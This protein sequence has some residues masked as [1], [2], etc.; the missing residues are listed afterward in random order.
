MEITFLFIVVVLVWIYYDIKRRNLFAIHSVFIAK[1]NIL[2]LEEWID[3]HIQ[4]GF[5]K[6]YLYDN[7]KVKKSSTNFEK[8][9]TFKAGKV[10]KYGRD[11]DKLVNLSNS[12]I[13]EILHKIQHKYK[14]KVYFIEWA[15]KDSNG[16][17]HYKQ[18]EA[19][20]DCLKR[21]KRDKID[22]CANIDMDEYI[23]I[24]EGKDNDIKYYINTL[25]N[26]V[27]NV[28]LGQMRFD[29]R[30]NNINKLITEIDK[31]EI[32]DINKNISPKN[33][34]RVSNTNRLK[35]HTWFG[36]G[37]QI[38]PNTDVICFNHYKLDH[39]NYKNKNNV[40]IGIKNKI[41]QNANTYIIKTCDLT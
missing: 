30:F 22:W 10:N 11:Y 39:E 35:I 34:Y 29:S 32:D 25:K 17:V 15:P 9:E 3:Y 19:H 14:N 16:V 24:N 20:M 37:N 12:E 23:T 38:V 1:E 5:D 40:N 26:N 13:K 7:S 28:R 33:L 27:C 18:K 6:F 31:N 21:L 41:K 36:H 4:L 2:F 8:H